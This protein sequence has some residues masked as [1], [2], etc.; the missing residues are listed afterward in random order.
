M[1]RKMNTWTDP[2]GRF[3]F[4]MPYGWT[5]QPRKGAANV[6]DFWRTHQ[7]TGYTAHFT[8]EMRSV[9]PNVKVAHYANKVEDEVKQ[10]ARAYQLHSREKIAI[11][12]TNGIR[13]HFTH[14][15]KNNAELVDEVIRIVFMAPERAYVLTFEYA[16]G[17]R[18]VFLEE[19]DLILKHF[20][21]RGAGEETMPMPKNK[22]PVRAGEMIDERAVPY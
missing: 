5:A 15:E 17:T 4:D 19:I 6:V 8:V 14:Q 21:G 12:G 1:G 3:Y 20:V 10:I 18:E 7:D 9:P 2:N 22:K 13:T 16:L 11:S